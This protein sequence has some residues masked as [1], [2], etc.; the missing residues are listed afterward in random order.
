MFLAE[1][2]LLSVT[3]AS[4]GVLLGESVTRLVSRLYPV[5]APGTPWWA[6]AAAMGIALGTGILFGVLP[7]RRAAALDPV[8]AL[9]RRWAMRIGDALRLSFGAL[10]AHRLRSGLTAAGIAVGIAAVVILTSFGEGLHRFVLSEFTQFGTNLLAV[11]PGKTQTMGFS[12]AVLNTVRPLSI[13]DAE[14]I[15]RLPRVEAAVPMVMGN[16]AVK[17]GGRSRRTSVYGVGHRMPEV[18]KFQVGQGD[19]PSRRRSQFGACLRGA[20]DHAAA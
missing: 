2:V 7:A 16:A 4:V 3:G 18:W 13:E 19:V 17:F 8:L 15:A 1:A 5:L 11:T 10:A 14:A 9:S 20:G 12:G 6:A